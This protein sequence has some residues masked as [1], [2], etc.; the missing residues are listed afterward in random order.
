MI[1]PELVPAVTNGQFLLRLLE[2]LHTVA[3]PPG[4]RL[5]DQDQAMYEGRAEQTPVA[6]LANWNTI[7]Q[8]LKRYAVVLEPDIKTL[9]V[10][11]DTDMV[12]DTLY[13]L[14]KKVSNKKLV[15]TR[16][17]AG[18]AL[19][20]PLASLS[21]RSGGLQA[22]HRSAPAQPTSARSG[23]RSRVVALA[24]AMVA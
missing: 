13:D 24:C 11:G 8:L 1:A 19:C 15:S 23:A 3:L 22:G 4:A 5:T 16:A 6:R 12:L 10:A 14:H 7:T 17:V 9:I 18:T 20:R 21:L 2:R